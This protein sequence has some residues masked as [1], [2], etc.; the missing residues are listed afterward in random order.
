M[1]RLPFAFIDYAITLTAPVKVV[2]EEEE[3]G[4]EV[5]LFPQLYT[6]TDTLHLTIQIIQGR[7]RVKLS[8]TLSFYTP[9]RFISNLKGWEKKSYDP[10]KIS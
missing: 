9:N 8:A 7:N 5:S 2:D 4:E 3:D 6:Q 10:H 1:V